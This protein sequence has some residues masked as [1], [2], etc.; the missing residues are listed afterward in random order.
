MSLFASKGVTR[1]PDPPPLR[2]DD[3]PV[4]A[5]G[6]ALWAAALLVLVAL[7]IGGVEVRD[8]WLQMCGYGILLGLIGVRYCWSRQK[9]GAPGTLPPKAPKAPT[10]RS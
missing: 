7:R 2:T 3:V 1:R 5:A 4:V 8:W 9:A 10:R 6:T